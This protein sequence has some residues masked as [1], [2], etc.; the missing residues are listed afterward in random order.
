MSRVG[1]LVTVIG[2]SPAHK[3][4]C[5][6]MVNAASSGLR[7]S[8]STRSLLGRHLLPHCLSTSLHALHLSL[9]AVRGLDSMA[10]SASRFEFAQLYR[11]V[12]ELLEYEEP[13]WRGRP[14]WMFAVQ[15]APRLNAKRIAYLTV[16]L[17]FHLLGQPAGI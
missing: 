4:F 17:G 16:E 14:K 7:S 5:E 3:I 11:S 9:L 13:T 1:C 15:E 10:L 2:A 6:E 12:G 8:H